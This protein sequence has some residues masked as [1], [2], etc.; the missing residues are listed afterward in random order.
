MKVHVPDAVHV[1]KGAIVMVLLSQC[2]LTS[3]LQQLQNLDL[4]WFTHLQVERHHLLSAVGSEGALLP[5]IT[6][7]KTNTCTL[8][9]TVYQGVTVCECLW[10]S[11]WL[12]II[13]TGQTTG[14]VGWISAATATTHSVFLHSNEVSQNLFVHVRSL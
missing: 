12:Q 5:H 4:C 7:S 11:Y 3:E 8:P 9:H 1:F 2:V 10:G 13:L 14:D 6:C